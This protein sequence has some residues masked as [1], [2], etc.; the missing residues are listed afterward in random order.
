MLIY[1]SIVYTASFLIK[2][3]YSFLT[4]MNGYKTLARTRGKHILFYCYVI[5]VSTEALPSNALINCCR[6]VFTAAL[7]SN[8]S[9]ADRHCSEETPLSLWL[10]NSCVC[11]FLW[12]NNSC[13]GHLRIG[14]VRNR[15]KSHPGLRDSQPR[16]EQVISRTQAAIAT[17]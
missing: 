15:Y 8:V 17:T 6:G 14:T 9:G 10:R 3:I 13:V 1:L 5:I 16:W 7:P 2:L 4:L 11:R 12:L